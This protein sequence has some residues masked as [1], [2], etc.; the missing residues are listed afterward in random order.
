[1]S[2]TR[3]ENCKYAMEMAGSGMSMMMG[4]TMRVTPCCKHKK[5][6]K[7]FLGLF[8]GLKKADITMDFSGPGDANT[9]AGVAYVLPSSNF[10]NGCRRYSPR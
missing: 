3:F 7:P 6:G 5:V 1:M 9:E 2:G 4:I 10:C 8:G